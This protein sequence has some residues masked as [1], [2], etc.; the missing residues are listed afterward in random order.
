MI[1]QTSPT[2]IRLEGF[3][4]DEIEKIRRTLT[5]RRNSAV[6]AYNRFRQNRY[7][8][9][10][11][12]RE[13]YNERLEELRS[14]I[15][16]CILFEDEEGHWTYPG[17]ADLI[18]ER[19]KPRKVEFR[20]EVEYPPPR[21]LRWTGTPPYDLRDYQKEIVD[22]LLEAKH[23]G[24]NCATGLGKSL[25]IQ[26]LIRELGHQ[27]VVV[28][29]SASIALQLY[30]DLAS[31]FGE[32]MVG[33]VG[34]GKRQFGKHITVAIAASLANLK[35]GTKQYDQIASAKILVFD[36]SHLAPAETFEKVCHGV[37]S[38]APYRFFVSG[39]QLRNDG[40][41]LL[42]KA[43]TG[44]IVYHMSVEEGVDRGWLAKPEFR[45][46]N[47]VINEEHT[48]KDALKKTRDHFL[49]NPTVN[50]LAAQFANL[51]VEAGMQVVILI[52]EIE[53]FLHL[54]PLLR[55]DHRFA[56]GM[57]PSAAKDKL[58]PEY[59]VSKTQEFV[60]Q[61]NEKKYPILVG[62]SCISTGT[63]IQTVD[64]IV[65]LKGGKSEIVFRQA[66]GR[67]TRK[68]PGKERFLYIDFDVRNKA[69]PEKED[70]VH[71]H[72]RQRV[73]IYNDIYGPVQEVYA[74]GTR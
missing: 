7:A 35:E 8:A 55:H 74:G 12:S 29:P 40:A 44:P 3:S 58:P 15:S 1:I 11:M 2:V 6:Y 36:E 46:V 37:L 16:T 17:V 38:N 45:M 61:F 52:D 48:S 20:S 10:S 13:A 42:L 57:A 51:S 49:Y 22:A 65:S 53:Q 28:A 31:S 34:D 59:H 32:R 19:L 4:D 56:H 66:V 39:T 9:R 62:T 30:K 47:V 21:Q 68:P 54:Y 72:A 41:D 26:Y 63:D 23:A 25:V 50:A 73:E 27:A 43:I 14:Q 69:L 67:G 70:I 18:R 60:D 71:R 5:F 33:M 24:I 64:V